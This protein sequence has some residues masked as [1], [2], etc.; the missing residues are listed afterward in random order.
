MQVDTDVWSN[1]KMV[2]NRY[3][4]NDSQPHEDEH[5]KQIVIGDCKIVDTQYDDS[6]M[7]FTLSRSLGNSPRPRESIDPSDLGDNI[8]SKQGAHLS[9]TNVKVRS[10]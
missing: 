1:H 9:T 3:T 6:V 8:G 4:N 10:T 7:A 2:P 5:A